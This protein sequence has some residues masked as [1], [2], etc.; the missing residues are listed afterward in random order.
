MYYRPYSLY[1]YGQIDG[2]T[3]FSHIPRTNQDRLLV[4]ITQMD[5][6]WNES[7]A[8][9]PCVLIVMSFEPN[10]RIAFDA[11]YAVAPYDDL[12]E[13]GRPFVFVVTGSIVSCEPLD[14]EKFFAKY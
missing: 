13:S 3:T 5:I 9:N 11:R 6:L 1:S 2:R 4:N 12:I 8:V 10:C 14:P 7:R